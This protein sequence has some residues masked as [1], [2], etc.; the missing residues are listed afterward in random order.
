MSDNNTNKT[1]FFTGLKQEF[2]KISWP[3]KDQVVKQSI[4]V[5]VT[6]FVVGVLIA[7]IDLAV[8]YGINL[9]AM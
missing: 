1:S 5:V 7:L 6:S 8:Q 2:A 9:L 4:A 3:V